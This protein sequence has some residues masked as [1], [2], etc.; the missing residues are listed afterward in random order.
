MKAVVTVPGKINLWLEVLGKRPDGYHEVSTL[1]LPVALFDRLVL[2]P[3]GEGIRLECAH[4]LV[5]VD[6]R[7]LIHRAAEAFFR[8]TGW[9][10]GLRVRL[11]KAVPVGA[12]M[13]GGS[14]DAAAVLS[15]L[16][17][18][19]PRALPFSALHE[20]AR[21]LGADVPFFLLKRPALATGVGDA[22]KPISGLPRYPLVLI[23][24][25]FEVSAAWAYG[26]LKLTRGGSRINIDT[27]LAC[28]HNPASCLEN[29][30][31]DAVSARHPEVAAI[32]GWLL[33]NGA[34]G[35]LMTGSGPTVFGIFESMDH[36]SAVER[37]ARRAWASCWCAATSTLGES[38][39]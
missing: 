14:A 3:Q 32:K 12:G 22:L 37:V 15:F 2:E 21:S 24:P 36:A 7:N 27:L 26:S 9:R 1:M 34:V 39:I 31:E 11:D 25:P 8:K 6:E 4:P 13:G 5:P 17:E 19:A 29:D 10:I 16:N 33:R 20:L 38:G 18:M 30:L 23:K 28:P 35:A